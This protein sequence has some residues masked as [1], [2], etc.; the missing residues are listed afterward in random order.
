MAGYA[1][2]ALVF[3]TVLY[4]SSVAESQSSEDWKVKS[5]IS[6]DDIDKVKASISQELDK[7]QSNAQDVLRGKKT[8]SWFQTDLT[9]HAF[10]IY[11]T[12][13][14]TGWSVNNYMKK[15]SSLT[16]SDAN[17]LQS[18]LAKITAPYVKRAW[19]L[20]T[21][22]KRGLKLK[23]AGRNL[24][25]AEQAVVQQFNVLKSTLLKEVDEGLAAVT[26]KL[27]SVYGKQ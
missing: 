15:Q 7:C 6:A 18:E 27:S 12:L 16:E 9:N 22:L 3:L 8:S 24:E 5:G 26:D 14:V 1:K 23:L 10:E 13:R 11:D 20:E 17:Q 4:Y 25:E 2:F 21:Q 19:A